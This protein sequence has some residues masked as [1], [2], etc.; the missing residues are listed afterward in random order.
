MSEFFSMAPQRAWIVDTE[1]YQEFQIWKAPLQELKGALEKI[2]GAVV[3]AK[4]EAWEKK[5]LRWF[6]QWAAV[7]GEAWERGC[8]VR[9]DIL[10]Y[11]RDITFDDV[12]KSAVKCDYGTDEVYSLV[13]I[14]EI[15]AADIEHFSSLVRVCRELPRAAEN[16]ESFF[17]APS[18]NFVFDI[19]TIIDT[20]GQW[21]LV[22]SDYSC[23]V[24][25]F[26]SDL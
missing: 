17:P 21:N 4:A 20:A 3:M 7:I 9:D 14:L 12:R 1:E 11:L 25:P 24:S 16:H 22:C 19:D 8:T 10:C 5:E 26:G 23:S 15:M 6:S 18:N 2:R 13:H